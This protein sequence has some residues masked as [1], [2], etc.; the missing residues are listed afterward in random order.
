MTQ[1]EVLPT[2]SIAP[3]AWDEIWHLT[4]RCY[5]FDDVE[6]ATTDAAPLRA[7]GTKTASGSESDS[8][9]VRSILGTLGAKTV[10]ARCEGL[11]AA[12]WRTAHLRGSIGQC[13]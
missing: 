12:E 4:H 13:A 3:G 8:E 1:I 7:L 11:L 10:A 9:E 6:E 5:E 2:A